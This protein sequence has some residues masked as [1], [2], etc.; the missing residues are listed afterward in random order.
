MPLALAV[1]WGK[2]KRDP[3]RVL[4]KISLLSSLHPAPSL[5]FCRPQLLWFVLAVTATGLNPELGGLKLLWEFHDHSYSQG[6]NNE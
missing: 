1:T 2:G 3:S 4:R 6:E 5:Q